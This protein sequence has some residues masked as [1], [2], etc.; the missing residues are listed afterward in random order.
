[1]AQRDYYEVLGV[2][3]NASDNEIKKAYRKLAIK[4]HPDKNQ[5]NP[6]AE[7]KFKEISEAYDVLNNP[8]KRSQFDQFGF[9]GG[10]G[11]RGGWG[12]SGSGVDLEDA[13]RTFMG[14]FGSGG[15][16]FDEIFG[17]GSRQ[18]SKGSYPGSNLRYDLEISFENSA[19][20]IRKEI[21]LT[22]LLTCDSCN[23]N[24]TKDQS[25]RTTCGACGGSGSIRQTQGFF[26]ISRACPRCNG[27]GSIVKNPC[28]S[29][30]GR[31]RK[32]KI[33]KVTLNIP[34]G[35][36]TGTQLKIYGEGESGLRGGPP[37]DLYVVIHV[38]SHPIFQRH[39]DDVLCEVPIPFTQATLGGEITVPTIDG[40]VKLKI[41]EGT[42]TGRTFRLK[43]KGIS[44]IHGYG[45]GDQLVKAVIET[46]TRLNA[47][48][49]EILN[50]FAEITGA[51]VHPKAF[52][53]FEKVKSFI[54]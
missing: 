43:G 35:V 17:S 8:Q 25:G 28:K 38:A 9:S 34:E 33:K 45:R 27:D 41:P 26:S 7:A 42:Q 20:G 31:G 49:K 32:E 46:P 11:S 30:Q 18:K 51:E 47:R 52:S 6:D 2:S 3:K 39:E 1:M 36:S 54:T 29:C 21:E 48:A 53:F 44:N 40:K 22:R 14:E 5:G 24:G 16:I 12:F 13:L 37:G 15:S 19:H 50:E 23:G 4:Y 10:P